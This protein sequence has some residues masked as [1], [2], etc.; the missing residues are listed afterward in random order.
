MFVF[1]KI[2]MEVPEVTVLELENRLGWL[3]IFN[4]LRPRFQY[5][6]NLAIRDH[7]IICFVLL[8]LGLDETSGELITDDISNK[9]SKDKTLIFTR[10]ILAQ[11][12]KLREPVPWEKIARFSY[13]YVTTKDDAP[14]WTN[15]RNFITYTLLGTR[16]RVPTPQSLQKLIV[17]Y[18]SKDLP[19][20][21]KN[22]NV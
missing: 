20:I 14:N 12:S 16:G 18:E 1:Y 6:L 5:N 15:R 21:K 4:P 10:D 7:R 3:N 11:L 8:S 17:D 19:K 2:L 13:G 9:D 22:L